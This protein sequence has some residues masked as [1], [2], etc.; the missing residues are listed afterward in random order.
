MQHYINRWNIFSKIIQP[1]FL[2]DHSHAQLTKSIA[3]VIIYQ[4]TFIQTNQWTYMQV[5]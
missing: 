3:E 5:L 1:S 2:N 4:I